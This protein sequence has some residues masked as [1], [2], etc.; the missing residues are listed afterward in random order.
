VRT[1]RRFRAVAAV[2]VVACALASIGLA[3]RAL[4]FVLD[5]TCTDCTADDDA[6]WAALLYLL[7]AGLA[8]VAS[9]RCVVALRR[10][11]GRRKRFTRPPVPQ[12]KG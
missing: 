10:R 9:G 3:F 5:A 1:R 8:A 6:P 2:G 11:G 7:G 4:L 12:Q